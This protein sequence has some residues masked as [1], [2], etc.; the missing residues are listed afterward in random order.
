MAILSVDLETY[1]SVDLTKAGVHAYVESADFE[2]LLFGYAWDDDPVQ[3]VDLAQGE[4]IPPGVVAA[5]TTVLNIKTAWNAAFERTCL[6]RHQGAQM[7]ADQWQCS[8]VHSYY[9]G[10]PGRLETAA[11][12][13][14]LEHEKDRAGKALIRYFSVPCK[15]T[16]KNGGRTRNLPEHDPEKWEALKRYCAQ[17]VE[18]ERAVRDRLSKFDVPT[19]E[20]KLWVI[21]QA[22]NDRGVRIDLPLVAEA[23]KLDASRQAELKS[24]AAEIT[25]LD[26]PGSVA[27]LKD[28]IAETDGAVVESLNKSAVAELIEDTDNDD[29]QRVLELRQQLAKASIKKYEAMQ[30][31][32]SSDGLARGLMQFYGAGRTGRWAGRRIQPQNMP[33]ISLSD[34]DLA[35]SVLRDGHGTMLDVLWD[36]AAAVLSQLVRTALVPSPGRRF[37][38]CDFSAIEAR[39]LAW[40]AGEQWRLDVFEGNG[41]IYEASAALMFHVPVESITKDHPLRQKGKVAELAL[42]YGGSVGALK[43]MGALEMGLSEHELQPLVDAW[44]AANTEI[45]KYWSSLE[46]AARLAVRGEG[47]SNW[48]VPDRGLRCL[49]KSGL[50]SIGLP[51][52]RALHYARPQIEPDPK[53]GRDGLTYEGQE[54]GRG[55]GRL[56]TWGG[57]LAENVTQA[58]ARDCLAEAIFRLD[59]A[60]YKIAVHVHDEVVIDAPAGFGSAEAVAE[61]MAAPIEWAPG[62]PLAADAF[63]CDYYQK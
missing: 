39:V 36:N 28:W 9:L 56:R 31:A 5:L 37:I 12:S 1:S 43:A 25:G 62:L 8:M 40:L 33:R 35:R 17:D 6:S 41:K 4:T 26:N 48:P 16:K 46:T 47:I 42:G 11:K 63:E 59:T 20:R 44:R 23:I 15:P 29:V 51:A 58:I 27:Q 30:R 52:G 3:V 21:D 38:V 13:L 24:E 61:I 57:K 53:F 18:V 22:I 60:G 45:V 32:V 10:L 55:W 49:F 2:I 19:R 34:L 7:P 50:L 54:Q 14:K